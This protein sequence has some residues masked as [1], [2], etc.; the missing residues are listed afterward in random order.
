[1]DHQLTYASVEAEPGVGSDPVD[2]PRDA[3]VDSRVLL[4]R[5]VEA[6][7]RDAVKQ[8]VS[9]RR[10]A[11]ERA[12]RVALARVL[13]ALRVA[14]AEHVPGDLVVV[15]VLLVAQARADHRHVDLVQ[16]LL[17]AGACTPQM[18]I[19]DKRYIFYGETHDPGTNS[20]QILPAD[21]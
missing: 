2:E 12:A 18:D 5:A 19:I 21:T 6:P 9:R 13:A 20:V 15:P 16:Q 10:Q 4:L 1:M 7:A 14:G 8:P 11:D 3:R 17:V